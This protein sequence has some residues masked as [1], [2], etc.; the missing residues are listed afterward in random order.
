MNTLTGTTEK[1]RDAMLEE[2]LGE[3]VT[4]SKGVEE[5]KASLGSAV[6]DARANIEKGGELAA[7]RVANLLDDRTGRLVQATKEIG[8]LRELLVGEIAAAANA[9]SI[10]LFREEVARAIGER[11]STRRRDLLIASGVSAVIT[12]TIVAALHLL[13]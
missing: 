8:A 9:D 13:H 10:R 7:L 5:L 11:A 1:V 4:L 3:L 6:T 12:I 2:A